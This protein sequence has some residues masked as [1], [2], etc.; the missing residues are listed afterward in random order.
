MSEGGEAFELWKTPQA[1]VYVKVYIFNVT[2]HEDFLAGI[3]EKLRFQEVGPYVYRYE[4][5]NKF[6][7]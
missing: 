6:V 3:D 4:L 2:N 7:L 5:S 1:A